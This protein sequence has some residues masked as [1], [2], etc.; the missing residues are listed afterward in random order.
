MLIFIF[1]FSPSLYAFHKDLK[2]ESDNIPTEFQFLFEGMKFE[3]KKKNDQIQFLGLIQD[4]G[5]NLGYL[6]KEHIYL[7]LKSEITKNLL[8]HKFDKTRQYDITL[9]LIERLEERMKSHERYL[10][11]FSK[12]IFKSTAAE[13]RFRQKIGL[14]SNKS[15][16]PAQ[17]DG[18]LKGEALRFSKLLKYLMPWIDKCLSLNSTEFNKLSTS[19]GWSILERINDRS[20]LF[21]RFSNSSLS[22]VKIKLFNIPQKLLDVHPE[23]LKKLQTENESE[24]LKDK[25]KRE[26]VEAQDLIDKATINDLSPIS[27]DIIKSIEEKSN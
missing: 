25:S 11:P 12:W 18:P 9:S 27:D 8:E 10:N 13:L 24:N 22:D 23:E 2:I 14:I 6:K 3:L 17:F 21:K 19:V 4:I 15:F 26:K 5:E 16:N 7:L 20:L 1:F